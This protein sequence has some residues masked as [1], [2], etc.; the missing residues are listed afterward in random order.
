MDLEKRPAPQPA[1]PAR[2][3]PPRPTPAPQ[4]PEGCLTA[5]IRIPVRIVVLVLVLPVRMAWDALVVAGRFL[6][7]TVLRPAGRALLWLAKAVL[8]WPW[9]A[10][11]RHVVVPAAKGLGRLGYWL[12]VLPLV[13]L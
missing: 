10:L 3:T 13:W 7:D 2:R 8:V 4:A 12:L 6:N 5:A 1:E 11:W 9:V